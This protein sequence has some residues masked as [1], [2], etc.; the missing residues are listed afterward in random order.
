M[1]LTF[2]AGTDDDFV[3]SYKVVADTV[4]EF[5]FFSDFY[6][7]LTRM[8]SPVEL[9]LPAADLADAGRVRIY[10]VDSWGAQSES[11]AEASLFQIAE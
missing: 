10:A 7:G 1:R 2:C 9:S 6:N 4:R 3:H 11:F 8:Q 5:L